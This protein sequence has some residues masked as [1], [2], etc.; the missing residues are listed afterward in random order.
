ME[1]RPSNY[2]NEKTRDFKRKKLPDEVDVPAF[3]VSHL[4]LL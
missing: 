1:I 3:Q 4:I 2:Y